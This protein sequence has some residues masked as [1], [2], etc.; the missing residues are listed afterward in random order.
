MHRLGD[1]PVHLAAD[2]GGISLA[3]LYLLDDRGQAGLGD[4]PI[5]TLNGIRSARNAMPPEV[6]AGPVHVDVTAL[7]I[8]DQLG[9]MDLL[10]RMAGRILLPPSLPAA[11]LQMEETLRPHQPA[12]LAAMREVVRLIG[13]TTIGIIKPESTLAGHEHG[14]LQG[15]RGCGRWF[16]D[17]DRDPGDSP[18]PAPHA[19][20]ARLNLRGMTDALLAGGAIGP[21]V[22]RAALEGLGR[23]GGRSAIG[24]PVRHDEVFLADLVAVELAEA[25][26]LASAGRTFRLL[27]DDDALQSM[28]A[29]IARAEE[30]EAHANRLG[31]LRARVARNL[32]AGT[33]STLP[34]TERGET[35]EIGPTTRCLL[36]LLR[37]P[38]V[39]GGVTWIDD[40]HITAHGLC[41]ANR[42]FDTTAMLEALAGTEWITP[43]ERW[44][45]V[46]RLREANALFVP[47][48]ADEVVHHLRAAPILDGELVETTAL[49][50]LRRYM[51]KA[52]AAATDLDARPVLAG[53]GQG[54]VPFLLALRRLTEDTLLAIWT[55]EE[56]TVEERE[57]RSSWVWS[58]LRV[59]QLPDI[60]L[61]GTAPGSWRSLL[62]LGY[63]ALLA[64][65]LHIL[66]Q[67]KGADQKDRLKSYMR[68][69]G[70]SA[71][72]PWVT[73]DSVFAKGVADMLAG[74]LIGLGDESEGGSK[75]G[76]EWRKTLQALL[77]EV[78]VNV[79][80]PFHDHLLAL[81]ALCRAAGISRSEAIVIGGLRF[82]AS[83]LWKAVEA[84]LAG[85]RASVKTNDGRA[86][87]RLKTRRGGT[88]GLALSGALE[89]VLDDPALGLLSRD[90]GARLSTARTI[91]ES[92]G[93]AA[94][95]AAA[96]VEELVDAKRMSDRMDEAFRLREASIH[97]RRRD[98]QERLRSRANIP[99]SEFSPPDPRSLLRYVGLVPGSSMPLRVRLA[100]AA[101]GLVRDFGAAEAVRRL[102]SLPIPLPD[103]VLASIRTLPMPERAGLLTD[104][105]GVAATPT[106]RLHCLRIHRDLC[107]AGMDHREAFIEA[108]RAL[109]A[110]WDAHT[111]LFLVVLK[112]FGEELEPEGLTSCG[113]SADEATVLAWIHADH[114][115]QAFLAAGSEPVE[116]AQRFSGRP[117]RREAARAVV[118][119]RGYDD[120]AAAPSSMTS[121][122]LL[123]HGLGY[124]LGTEQPQENAL[125]DLH[126]V[127][128]LRD[129]L[130]A[131]T[132]DRRTP[133]PWIYADR[134]GAIDNLGTWFCSR[135]SWVFPTEV[136]VTTEAARIS[137]GSALGDLNVAQAG[138]ARLWLVLSILTMP[139]L[140]DERRAIAAK[141]VSSVDLRA[142][143]ENDPAVA[144]V[145]LRCAAQIAQ[146]SEDDAAR[147]SFEK[148][149]VCYA[150]LLA[151]HRGG[152]LLPID[153]ES[154][155]LN[156]VEA[157]AA[158]SRSYSTADGLGRFGRLMVALAT[159]WPGI[160]PNVRDVVGTLATE[161]HPATS[162]P[163]Q[164]SWL[165]LRAMS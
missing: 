156:L 64:N 106:Q 74:M 114:V 115:T 55:A 92:L 33:F 48:T 31:F 155:V 41:G 111:R 152:R 130:S 91:V 19:G 9:L 10:E 136:G 139:H 119:R 135:P 143:V 118:F 110:L 24:A 158:C 51:A 28:R 54:E 96:A 81:P 126:L 165:R 142:L 42:V 82:A 98:L 35:D 113:L 140:D 138:Q 20:M 105:G 36:E 78:V 159:A 141:A 4:Y 63:A 86:M 29:D 49:A 95:D 14:G 56:G 97:A 148:K 44:A 104:L 79:P 80:E 90:R 131:G 27:L 87:L 70:S 18:G 145:A 6:G 132:G 17:F 8:A 57:V 147:S 47:I 38:G 103:G 69:L 45:A 15:D 137:V 123:F 129:I 89:G 66:L 30:Q 1:V 112:Q 22:H 39:E 133:T 61:P 109:P 150:E 124:A 58:S 59:D 43:A 163:I 75:L 34:A 134:E 107:G 101:L 71:V 2:R 85:G 127:D 102:A 52:L 32:V 11:L 84:A 65:G 154:V 162:A 128:G 122:A 37:A 94:P 60:G 12:R 46:L 76:R 125:P 160:V 83:P 149:L 108:L 146:A 93:L 164:D 77:G 13:T 16:L 100:D 151:R 157:A 68:W 121:E 67:V 144:M 40:R 99:W 153:E 23:A 53:N 72:P 21:D 62:T 3:R 5:F 120:A 73:N 26:I 116:A 7:L 25:G 161:S 88:T 117:V 50:T